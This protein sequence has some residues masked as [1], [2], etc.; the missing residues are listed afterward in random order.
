ML[1][2]STELVARIEAA[3][4]GL[5]RESAEAVSASRPEVPVLNRDVAG[6]IATWAG[7]ESPLNK[8]AGLGFGGP[9]DEA[10][11]AAVEGAFAER[12]SPV[13]VELATLADPAVGEMLTGRGYRLVAFENVLGR[14][15]PVPPSEAVAPPGPVRVDRSDEDG[16]STWLD[17]MVT[18]FLHPDGDGIP[19]HQTFPRETLERVMGDL[20]RAESFVQYIAHIRGETAGGANMRID[21][22]VAQLAGAATLPAHRR[23][24]VQAAL[25]ARRLADAAEAGCD[26]AVVTTQP[27]SASQ[28]N[29]QRKGFELLY[30]RA[31]LVLDPGPEGPGRSAG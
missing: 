1:F 29:A 31:V 16:F 30:A 22:G 23:R 14:A 19:P 10:T 17:A 28:R 5:L 4:C 13:Q 27:G 15:L 11:M 21:R 18:G 3:E 7:P 24:G 8:V 6:G 9:V 26:V 25:L 12:G 20:A 2:A